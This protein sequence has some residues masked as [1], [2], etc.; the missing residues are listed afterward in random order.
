MRHTI[1]HGAGEHREQQSYICSL[2]P[3]NQSNKN[4]FSKYHY[5]IRI[6]D[7]LPPPKKSSFTRNSLA[8]IKKTVAA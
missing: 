7:T 5:I 3:K 1:S 2:S 6:A 4:N 8:H